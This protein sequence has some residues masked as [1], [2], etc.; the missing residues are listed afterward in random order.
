MN[1]SFFRENPFFLFWNKPKAPQG[2][3]GT[4]QDDK[5]YFLELPG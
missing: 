1:G 2:P 4:P 5:K 3:I